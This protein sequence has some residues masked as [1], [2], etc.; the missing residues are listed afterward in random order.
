MRLIIGMSG[1][2]G[3][4]YGIRLL[5]VLKALPEVETHLV[6]SNGAKL[7][8]ALETDWQVKAVEALADVVHSDQNL[9]ATIASGS[10]VTDGMIIAPCSMK[11]L[12]GVVNSFAD[13]L[14]V[15][16]AD[17]VL[18]EQRRL[19]IVPRET[20]L[21]VG[22]CRLMHE[23][24][25]MGSVIVPP[26]PAFYNDP[27][28]VDDIINHTVGRLIDLFGV[29]SGLVQRWQGAGNRGGK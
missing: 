11:T 22:H 3:V 14:V 25:Q 26:M 28:S 19:V 6:M 12:S 21:H 5:E 15:R 29:D 20:P 17:V 4:I 23:A 16:A 7:N 27:Q 24:A 9:A 18:K 2:S 1:A 10:Y 13:N 8:V